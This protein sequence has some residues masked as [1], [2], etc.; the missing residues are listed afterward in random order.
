MSEFRASNKV[1]L[2]SYKEARE[3]D[4]DTVTYI[5]LTDGSVLVVRKEYGNKKQNIIKKKINNKPITN[6]S[7]RIIN[8]NS[9][10]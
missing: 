8:K 3:L 6:L 2:I 4:L 5:V 10:Q 9:K 7:K 1:C